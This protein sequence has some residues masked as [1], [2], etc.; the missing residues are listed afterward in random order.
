M[1]INASIIRK[2]PNTAHKTVLNIKFLKNYQ[3]KKN[4][5][6][7]KYVDIADKPKITNGATKNTP[8]K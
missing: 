3:L 1:M 7:L 8:T 4:I 6:Y 2:G 5:L